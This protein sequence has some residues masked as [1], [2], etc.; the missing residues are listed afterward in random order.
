MAVPTLN[1]ITYSPTAWELRVGSIVVACNTQQHGYCLV[2]YSA[3]IHFIKK[4]GTFP[5]M[6]AAEEYADDLASTKGWCAI[7][8]PPMNVRRKSH[9]AVKSRPVDLPKW[10]R[11]IKGYLPASYAQIAELTG[12]Q[13]GVTRERLNACLGAGLIH[14]D[15]RARYKHSPIFLDGQGW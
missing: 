13:V 8:T 6:K 14:A 12:W 9:R 4:Y 11:E 1:I 10:Y 3:H 2:R 15:E 7:D 5:S